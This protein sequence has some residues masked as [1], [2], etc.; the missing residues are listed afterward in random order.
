MAN[1]VRP[2]HE[3]EQATDVDFRRIFEDEINLLYG[4]A[5]LLTQTMAS[6][7]GASPPSLSVEPA[8]GSDAM[9]GIWCAKYEALLKKQR[10][11]DSARCECGWEWRG[12]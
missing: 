7:R 10:L 5:L 12:A 4:L 11:S 6:P 2:K 3:G 1:A 8:L 9:W